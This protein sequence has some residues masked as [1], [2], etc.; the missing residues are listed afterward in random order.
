MTFKLPT[1]SAVT[2]ADKGAWTAAAATATNNLWTY[3][4]AGGVPQRWLDTVGGGTLPA[5]PGAGNTTTPGRYVEEGEVSTATLFATLWVTL[6]TQT[7]ALTAAANQRVPVDTTSAAFAV[8][9]P[10]A[11][12]SGTAAPTR[13]NVLNV[14]AA[15]VANV[16]TLTAAGTD[17]FDLPA[18][19]LPLTVA[20]GES[21]EVQCLVAGKWSLV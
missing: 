6:G 15:T 18:A 8:T 20:P 3:T 5:S 1:L 12:L 11:V 19:D 7:A 14:A 10:A 4:P 9:M 17:V 2:I 16:A 13:V 21:V